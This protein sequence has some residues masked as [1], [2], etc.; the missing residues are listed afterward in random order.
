MVLNLVDLA[1]IFYGVLESFHTPKLSKVTIM[2]SPSTG[3]GGQLVDRGD[4]TYGGKYVVNPSGGLISKGHPLGA[5]GTV[6]CTQSLS[7]LSVMERLKRAICTTARGTG[8]SEVDGRAE[9]G[10]EKIRVFI[11]SSFLP[12]LRAAVPL[13]RSSHSSAVYSTARYGTVQYSTVQYLYGSVGIGANPKAVMTLTLFH[14]DMIWLVCSWQ[15]VNMV[16]ID[17]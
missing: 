13:A 5:T 10:E 3:K 11:F 7:F 9:N 2:L 8:V 12:I 14:R 15:K 16:K 6:D 1:T 4:N 17:K